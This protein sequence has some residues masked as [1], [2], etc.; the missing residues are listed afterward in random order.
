MQQLFQ[1]SKKARW[2]I[3][4]TVIYGFSSYLSANTVAQST[5]IGQTL[6]QA[7]QMQHSSQAQLQTQNLKES[8]W[9]EW[10]LTQEDWLKYEELKK[11]ARGIW[12]PN[13]DPLTTLGVEA[14]TDAERQRYAELLVK[15][16][17]QRTLGEIAFQRAYDQAFKRLYPN[18]LPFG[19]LE[20]GS[21]KPSAAGRVIYFTK[22]DC[23]KECKAF[24]DDF[25]SL[26]DYVGKN[27]VDVYVVDS[28]QDDSKVQAWAYKNK[29][30]INKVRSQ[31]I[32][33]N[34]D[35]GYW[36]KQAKGKMPVAFQITGNNEWKLLA[37]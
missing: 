26:L 35:N 3:L 37:Y 21:H 16:E 19:S 1:G 8:R 14:K 10:G 25:V 33:I 2:T 7:S 29:V 18:E 9:L 15:K 20:E 31:Q 34:H 36:L 28:L 4:A 13:L 22:A 5:A 17:Y 11:G 24:E 12:S 32:T 27:P 30:D 23:G 6:S